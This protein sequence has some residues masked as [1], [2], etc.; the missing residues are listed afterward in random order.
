MPK[1]MPRS[2]E[3][4]SFFTISDFA[5]H[6]RTTRDTLLHYDKIGLISPVAR[7]ENGYRYYFGNQFAIVNVIRTFQEMGVTLKEI[8]RLRDSRTP[9]NTYERF[10]KR[11]EYIDAKIEEWIRA[12]KLLLTLAN[13]IK[14]VL[15]VDEKNVTLQYLP[16]QAMV[17]GDLND[18]RRG[19]TDY[20][21]FLAFYR[22]ISKKYPDVNLNFPVWAQFSQE[23]IEKGDWVWPD[24]FYFVNPEGQD[25][26]PEGL[27]VVGYTRGGYGQSDELYKRIM[28]YI[29]K[30]NLEICGDAYE[31]YPLN[32]VS[33]VD[34]T[35]YLMRVIIAVREKK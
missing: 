35:N 2:K 5:K 27:Y 12:K 1:F 31:E 28:D 6:S 16:A 19:K 14:S 23:R 30:N 11:V 13:I 33:I 7:G 32:E 4:R 34:D 25:S 20:D 29:D 21:A 9:E 18:Y 22:N 15:D 24:R 10:T 8:K 26:R 17:L 3:A